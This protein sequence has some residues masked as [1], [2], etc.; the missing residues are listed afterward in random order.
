[1]GRRNGEEG[2]RDVFRAEASLKEEMA[3]MLEPVLTVDNSTGAL[4]L[5]VAGKMSA[6]GI[7]EFRRLVDD[8]RRR[9]KPVFV[10]L[11]E[12]TLLDRTSAQYLASVVGAYVRVENAPQYLLNWIGLR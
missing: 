5:A 10:D 3:L 7:G 9:R 2:V 4:H 6:N 1:M 12:V 11:G 8:A